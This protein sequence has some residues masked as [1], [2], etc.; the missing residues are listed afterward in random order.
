M[1]KFDHDFVKSKFLESG[2]ELLEPY[3][4]IKTPL[5]C[6]CL[7]G[8]HI[9]YKTFNKIRSGNIGCRKCLGFEK[10]EYKVV[11][12]YFKTYDCELL[13]KD[14][15]NCETKLEFKCKCDKIYHKSFEKFKLSPRCHN[16]SNKLISESQSFNYEYVYKYF[17]EHGCELLETK[18]INAHTKM[19]FKC[20][21]GTIHNK[22]FMKF[23]KHPHCSKCG[24][25]LTTAKQTG[26]M[27]CNYNK[28]REYIKISRRSSILLRNL[29]KRVLMKTNRLK[30][31]NS[32]VMLGYSKEE[33]INHLKT[34][35][36]Y[37][38]WKKDPKNYHIDHIFPVTAFMEHNIFDPKI[39]NNLNNLQ[40]ISA[41]ENLS[42]HKKYNKKLFKE[43][44]IL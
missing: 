4:D 13:S 31:N 39:I 44:Y 23:R 19:K 29:L 18:Y 38:L 42:K 26:E 37:N 30:T 20:S 5:K 16:C 21:C 40:I 6:N 8:S 11:Y 33:L 25:R 41:K 1:K 10:P 14:Y 36:N 27:N 17:K 43:A 9:V 3:V 2:Y 15:K 24:R 28:D 7:K 34:S 12:D 35:P 32:E 22:T